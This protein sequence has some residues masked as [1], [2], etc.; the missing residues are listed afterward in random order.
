MESLRLLLV[1]NQS[2]LGKLQARAIYCNKAITNVES[3][4]HKQYGPF[5]GYWDEWFIQAEAIKAELT[6]N[7]TLTADFLTELLDFILTLEE[8]KKLTKTDR[9]YILEVHSLAEDKLNELINF[10]KD[11][12]EQITIHRQLTENLLLVE[13]IENLNDD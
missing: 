7:I 1:K 6:E 12:D 4:L 9:D 2:Y 10:T 5:C 3:D 8:K 11:I 13:A